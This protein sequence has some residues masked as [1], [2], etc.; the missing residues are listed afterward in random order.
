MHE[1]RYKMDAVFVINVFRI[2]NLV[3]FSIGIIGRRVPHS[4]PPT[5]SFICVSPPFKTC[6]PA[7]YATATN[8]VCS[9]FD[10]CRRQTVTLTYY[11]SC[12]TS[13]SVPMNYLRTPFLFCL[14]FCFIC[15]FFT[16]LCNFFVCRAVSVIGQWLLT[17][18][19]IN[20]SWIQF[21]TADMNN[22]KDKSFPL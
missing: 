7:K 12:N 3:H 1:R 20:K 14:C 9:D 2:Q 18:T 6:L 16:V 17:Q 19:A 22:F 4:E 13:W 10:I 8:T 21:Y 5:P 15:V 11:I